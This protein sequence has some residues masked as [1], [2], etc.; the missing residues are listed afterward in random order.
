MNYSS[1]TGSIRTESSSRIKPLPKKVVDR[2]AAGEVVQR[3]AS[4][5]KE[6]IENSLDASATSI[7]VQCSAG[8]MRLLSITDDG[9]GI[10]PDDLKL[11]A[12][13]FATSKLVSV[14][15]L[16]N[17]ETFGFRGEALASA[18][19]VGRLSIISRKRVRPGSGKSTKRNACAFKLNYADGEPC[20]KAV[21][22]A[23]KE[24]TCVKLEDLFYNLPSRKRAF[25]GSRKENEEYQKILEIVQVYAVHKAASGVGFVC[26]K[27][28]GATDINTTSMANIKKMKK[29]HLDKD[30]SKHGND[31]SSPEQKELR[32]SCTRDT[33][34]NIY[35]SEIVRELILLE[36]GEGDVQQVSQAA[37]EAMKSQDCIVTDRRN[38]LSLSKDEDSLLDE[39]IMGNDYG[40]SIAKESA[41]DT[42]SSQPGQFSFAF[43]A[44][45]FITNGSYCV[46]KSSSAFLLFINDRLVQSA[47]LKRA[48]EGVYLDILPKGAKPFVYLSLKLP[49]PHLDVNIHPTKREVAFLHEDRLCETLAANVRHALN[50]N[51]T[52][53]TFYTQTLLPDDVKV[54]KKKDSRL[55]DTFH[56]E[57]KKSKDPDPPPITENDNPS[58]GSYK[59]GGKESDAPKKRRLD[60]REKALHKRKPYD[61][62]TLIRTNNG[63]EQGALEPFLVRQKQTVI[64]QSVNSSQE[65]TNEQISLQAQTIAEPIESIFDHTPDC[66]FASK[67]NKID[68]NIP[69]AFASICRCQVK[70][71]E[72]LPTLPKISTVTPV[73]RPKKIVV[74]ACSYTSIEFLRNDI[75][76]RSHR[77]L[78]SKLRDSVFVGCVNRKRCLLQSGLELLMVNLY[79]LSKEL[80]YQ[81]SLLRFGGLEIAELGTGVNVKALIET[82]LS[83]ENSTKD[84]TIEG[85]SS[86]SHVVKDDANS[87]LASQASRCL[88]DQA[89]MLLE[90]FS[91]RLELKQNPDCQSE[92]TVVMLT[93]LPII[94]DGHT[95]SPHALP[96]FLFRLATCVDWTEERPCF[97]G[98][99]TELGNYYAEIPIPDTGNS[100]SAGNEQSLAKI[101]LISDTEKKFI[102][103]TIFPALRFLLVIP[104]EFSTDGSFCKLALLSKLYRVFER[105]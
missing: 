9:D 74:T 103:H 86:D 76:T 81:L 88:M 8:G 61:P 80:F 39:L 37:L 62:K 45:G 22:S 41:Q 99:C 104:K 67:S 73:M 15:D 56:G 14:D 6:L 18:S 44:Y 7:D 93:G 23:G 27:R 30:Q 77:E 29:F 1:S 95:P 66:E 78:T 70:R 84:S 53:R 60:V 12:T 35:G 31:Y 33:I 46:P 4:V 72:S 102:Q 97:E 65:S 32:E 87:K 17:M 85:I 50:S 54:K 3:P 105:C 40:A 24:G 90:Y 11:A 19:M 42:G 98:V 5:V 79:E 64:S 63:A 20:G 2:I 100:I 96:T 47:P 38:Q 89:E 59:K 58:F 16:K 21:P 94:V 92:E 55:D 13:R 68:M 69:G 36:C 75:K 51:T 43:K 52:S 10:H 91:I 83:F 25:E 34:G 57:E 49:G 48:V 26:R 71:A 28:G 82:H 101:E